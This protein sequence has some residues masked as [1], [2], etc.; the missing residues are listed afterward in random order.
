[1]EFTQFIYLVPPNCQSPKTI[2]QRESQLQSIHQILKGEINFDF[3]N[4]IFH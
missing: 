2:S 4:L 3:L 1:M